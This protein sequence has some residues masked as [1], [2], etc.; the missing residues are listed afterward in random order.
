MT[1]EGNRGNERAAGFGR[2]NRDFSATDAHVQAFQACELRSR[3]FGFESKG[4]FKRP[5]GPCYQ[6]RLEQRSGALQPAGKGFAGYLGDSS[7]G[8]VCR[9]MTTRNRAKQRE[10]TGRRRWNDKR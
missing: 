10:D 5:V 6:P 2:R 7:E 8:H 1:E 3:A 9:C 4:S